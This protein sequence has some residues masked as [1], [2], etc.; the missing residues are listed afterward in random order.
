MPNFRHLI[1]S[2]SCETL[3]SLTLNL[4]QGM[5]QGDK[6]VIATQSPKGEGEGGGEFGS[7]WN[8]DLEFVW[9]LEFGNWNLICG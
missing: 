2:N 1:E 6:I 3:K 5:V 4:I 7:F 9:D 8:W